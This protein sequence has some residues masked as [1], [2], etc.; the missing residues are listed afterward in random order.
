MKILFALLLVLLIFIFPQNIGAQ[1]LD[2][3]QIFHYQITA[4][5]D[6][7]LIY[8]HIIIPAWL[9]AEDRALVIFSEIFD[10]FDPCKMVYVPPGV[11]ILGI[12]FQADNSHLILN[13][14]ADIL[15][16]GGTHFEYRFIHMLL[17]NAAGIKEVSYLTVLIDGQQQ[18]FPEGTAIINF[19]TILM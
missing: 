13:L 10:N 8:Y 9:S 17:T 16:Y 6:E 15:N 2:R 1:E 5:Y 18:C 12:S 3:L 14:S 11:R 19:H 7:V 4:N